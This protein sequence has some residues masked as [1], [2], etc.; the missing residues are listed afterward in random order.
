MSNVHTVTA[1]KK[2][3]SWRT[4]PKCGSRASK[5]FSIDTGKYR[6]Q[7]CDHRYEYPLSDEPRNERTA[8]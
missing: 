5:I 3:T 1:P 4:C 7:I 2:V 6:C 8:P